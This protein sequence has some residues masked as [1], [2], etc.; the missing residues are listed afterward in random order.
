MKEIKLIMKKKF[1]GVE[2]NEMEFEIFEEKEKIDGIPETKEYLLKI[3]HKEIEK[4]FY[5][6]KRYKN[7]NFV[8]SIFRDIKVLGLKEV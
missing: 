8:S 1:V 2:E 3:K 7:M 4:I 5:G 6:E